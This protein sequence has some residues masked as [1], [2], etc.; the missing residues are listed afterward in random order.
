[1]LAALLSVLSILDAQA[2]A[3]QDA[4]YIYRN[5]GRFNAFFFNDIERFE[6]S[7][8]DTLGITHDEV[9]VQ[10]IYALDSLYRIPLTAI[11]SIGFVTPEIIFKKDV[12][13]TSASEMWNYVIG[14]D[15]SSVLLL[16]GN[17]PEMLIPKVGDKEW[18][19]GD[20]R[21]ARTDGS[22][23]P[24]GVQGRSGGNPRIRNPCYHT[25]QRG[26]H[27]RRMGPAILRKRFRPE[28]NGRHIL[29]PNRQ[30]VA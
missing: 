8:I 6:Y 16:A 7:N 24:V 19:T 30:L 1:M 4:L 21:D 3:V 2:Q 12:A 18:Y 5:D 23:R 26:I 20:L 25:S 13:H 27:C 17:T 11:D 29:F 10:E 15:S 9:V 28:A 22:L 14:S